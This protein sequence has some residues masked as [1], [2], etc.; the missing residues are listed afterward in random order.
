MGGGCRRRSRKGPGETRTRARAHTHTH[1]RHTAHTHTH[2]HTTTTRNIHRATTSK[3]ARSSSRALTWAGKPQVDEDGGRRRRALAFGVFEKRRLALRA[4]GRRGRKGE[5]S[6]AAPRRAA[7]RA[8]EGRRARAARPRRHPQAPPRARAAAPP[9]RPR[10]Q[11]WRPYRACCPGCRRSAP[12]SCSPEP[13][14]P[15]GRRGDGRG[16]AGRLPCAGHNG[17]QGTRRAS[18]APASRAARPA[19]RAAR[20]RAT[21]LGPCPPR[22]AAR[23]RL[24]SRHA[25]AL[26]LG[27]SLT[28]QVS[29]RKRAAV[30]A[31][32]RRGRKGGGRR[33][34]RHHGR[35]SRG[36]PGEGRAPMGSIWVNS[37][38]NPNPPSPRGRGGPHPRPAPAG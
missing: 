8:R 24:T 11:T 31:A 7:E 25:H 6:G 23:A 17:R 20:R 19:P 9:R 2:T 21:A 10:G 28:R 37:A 30:A 29:R 1:A 34:D 5:G 12:P 18:L 4:G 36:R 26:G 3:R 33:R 38:P 27:G 32:A 15:A 35:Q 14:A 22:G 13:R 16:R